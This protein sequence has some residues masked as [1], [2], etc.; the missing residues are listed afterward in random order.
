MEAPHPLGN[1]P[2]FHRWGCLSDWNA[3]VGGT[4]PAGTQG[5]QIRGDPDT[6]ERASSAVSSTLIG[7]AGTE[8]WMALKETHW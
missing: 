1:C 2:G 8:E 4:F 3:S 5:A 6:P 7:T